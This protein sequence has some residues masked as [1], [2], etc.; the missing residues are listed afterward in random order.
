LRSALKVIARFCFP[1]TLVFCD[2]ADL[3]TSIWLHSL[4]T[5]L[6]PNFSARQI[7]QGFA[8]LETHGR[9]SCNSSGVELMIT[10]FSDFR[11]IFGEKM[12]L[13]SKTNV[14][15]IFYKKLAVFS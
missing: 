5:K 15:I 12:A 1:F 2:L 14:T 11:Q 4:L 10:I 8:E 13:F 7:V 9:L 6:A 3:E